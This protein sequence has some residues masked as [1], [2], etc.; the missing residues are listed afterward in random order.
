MSKFVVGLKGLIMNIRQNQ[1]HFYK[2]FKAIFETKF[3]GLSKH[4][5][6]F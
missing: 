2:Q 1:Q 3:T 5:I 4:V 6:I